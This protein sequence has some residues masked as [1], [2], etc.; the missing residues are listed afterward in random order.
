[1][2]KVKAPQSTMRAKTNHT[3]YTIQYTTS[4]NV[5]IPK[6]D[7]SKL[8]LLPVP[9][10]GEWCCNWVN[11]VPVGVESYLECS[12]GFKRP[13]IIVEDWRL[14]ASWTKHAYPRSSELTKWDV[15]LVS[16]V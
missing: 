4:S 12:D 6:F 1:M 10:D 15:M 16:L 7:L 13:S 5:P 8:N 3:S 14:P 2:S 9:K 11:D